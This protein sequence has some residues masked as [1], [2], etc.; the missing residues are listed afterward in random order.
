MPMCIARKPDRTA[1]VKSKVTVSRRTQ[2]QAR[3]IPKIGIRIEYLAAKESE[4]SAMKLAAPGL[5][6]DDNEASSGSTGFR[7]K[8]RALKINLLNKVN[9]RESNRLL[10]GTLQSIRTIQEV[11][12]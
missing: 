9:A 11:R 10:T 1:D 3:L 5:C 7:G 8:I 2:R 12:I 4:G 6:L